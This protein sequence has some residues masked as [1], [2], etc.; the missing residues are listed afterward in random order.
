MS[1]LP[2]FIGKPAGFLERTPLLA[3]H[4]SSSGARSASTLFGG[5]VGAAGL[6]GW[7]A[8]VWYPLVSSDPER[9]SHQPTLHTDST[10]QPTAR[11]SNRHQ[12][13]PGSGG[14]MQQQMA[15]QQQDG[16]MNSRAEALQ[17]V[18]ATIVELGSIFTQLAEMVGRRSVV[19]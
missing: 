3:A 5:Q 18:E 8:F 9:V 16:Y 17:N 13:P 4:D 7:G 11:F 1:H 6:A 15:L 2:T 10:D 14:Q 19:V 12:G